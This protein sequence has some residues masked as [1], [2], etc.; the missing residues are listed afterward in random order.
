[1]IT[2]VKIPGL[3]EFRR[4]LT[5]HIERARN[6]DVLEITEYGKDRKPKAVYELKK[7]RNIPD[8]K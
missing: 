3:L 1:M 7:V 4:D 5:S 6:G 8:E 2:K